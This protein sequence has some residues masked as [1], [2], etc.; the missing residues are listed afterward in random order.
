LNTSYKGDLLVT[1]YDSDC[2]VLDDRQIYKH[3]LN[4]PLTREVI[5]KLWKRVNILAKQR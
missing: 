2:D 3:A 1:G 4:N 5:A